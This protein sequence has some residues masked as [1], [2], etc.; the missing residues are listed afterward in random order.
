VLSSVP[1]ARHADLTGLGIVLRLPGIDGSMSPTLLAAALAGAVL[2]VPALARWGT[3]H[4]PEPVTSPLWA[5][6]ADEF[7]PRMEYTAT[8]FAQPLQR[9]FDDVLRPDAGIEVTHLEETRY[10]VARIAYRAEVAD[11]VEDRIYT[12]VLRTI[13]AC[14]RATRHAH[15][16]SVHLYL[17]YGVL[18]VLI[19]LV[20]AR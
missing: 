17:A 7:T 3:R 9:V 2:V 14:A 16:G 13:A 6:G 12:P 15:N 5:C 11:A 8:S 18:G 20:V 4:R 19:V 10:H 1:A